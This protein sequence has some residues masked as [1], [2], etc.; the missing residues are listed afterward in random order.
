MPGCV[1]YVLRAVILTCRLQ[2]IGE[3]SV[4]SKL[5]RRNSVKLAY[6]SYTGGQD[7]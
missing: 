6:I 1:T 5:L 4:F 7:L 3:N 2:V